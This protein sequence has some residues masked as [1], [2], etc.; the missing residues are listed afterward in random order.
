M[1]CIICKSTLSKY[2]YDEIC[3]DCKFDDT[4]TIT[5]TNIKKITIDIMAI[6]IFF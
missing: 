1:S 3:K 2:V 6:M 4:I 5:I